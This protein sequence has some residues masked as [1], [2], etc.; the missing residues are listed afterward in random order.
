[1]KIYI[2]ISLAAALL[3]SGCQS[4]SRTFTKDQK[5]QVVVAS[6]YED[7]T[8]SNDVIATPKV[9]ALK[10][11]GLDDAQASKLIANGEKQ[12]AN[13]TTPTTLG[14]IVLIIVC[15]VGLIIILAS[16]DDFSLGML[17]GALVFDDD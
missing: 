14:W 3:L 17:V 8:T 9:K 13:D 2:V 11:L 12:T 6:V 15:I 16:G 10:K 7:G 1:M 5:G 4:V